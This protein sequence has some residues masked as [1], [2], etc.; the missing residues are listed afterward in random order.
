VLDTLP[1]TRESVRRSDGELAREIAD[2]TAGL[3]D[4]A[5]TELCNRFARRVMAYGRRHLSDE[6][7]ASD[8]TQR[9]LLLTLEKLRAGEVREPDRIGSFV[10]GVAR[11]LSR[12]IQ[13]KRARDGA[14]L[15]DEQTLVLQTPAPELEPLAGD[16]LRDCLERL[17]ER[18]RTIVVLSFFHEQ[19]SKEIAQALD[20]T[21]GNVRVIRH[22]AIDRLRGCMGLEEAMA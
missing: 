7:W 4:R 12:E 20:L 13:R 5:E 3:A 10:L 11:T 1:S 17:A 22:R 15:P 8:L 14:A 16:H 19:S 6:A 9:V 21:P 2:A 18:E